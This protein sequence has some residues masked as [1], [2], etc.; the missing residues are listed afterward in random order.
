MQFTC[1]RA[2]LT[3][4]AT[5]AARATAARSPVPALEGLLIEAFESGIVRITGYDLKIGIVTEIEADVQ[6]HGVVVLTA[7]LL[8]EIVR[9]MPGEDV[10]FTAD[11][12]KCR[13]TSEQSS[14][15]LIG[16]PAKEYPELP[17]LDGQKA[18]GIEGKLLRAVIGET[19]FAV[20]ESEARPVFSGALFE[21][22]GNRL[23]V[24]AV[25]GARLAL[26][27]E[28]I[29]NTDGGDSSFIVP[30]SALAE[31]E[32][33]VSGED[34]DIEIIA[35]DK[36]VMFR[37]ERT[38]LVARRIVGEFLN[39]RTTVPQSGKYAI[40]VSRRDLTDAVERVSL[41]ISDKVRTPLRCT[42]GD[43]VVILSA[44]STIGNAKD[45]CGAVGDGEGMEIGFN[46]KYL[47]DSL[48]AAPAETLE[49]RMNSPSTA[50]V[51]LPKD[52]PD[53]ETA[54]FVYMVLPVRLAAMNN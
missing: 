23:T 24:V 4:A 52:D 7:R 3:N 1:D 32:R 20:A 25:D 30:G 11:D 19:I 42:F 15:D 43:G 39:Y 44:V 2:A 12:N 51:I 13:L 34:G 6:S 14:F 18:Y 47:L 17:T 41:I 10:T 27:R 5:T 26:R 31:V 33:I 21:V 22:E 29:A 49:L 28:E 37:F 35:G 45:E 46:N 16:T 36:H 40:S 50:C 53:V 54:A 8:C 48:R 9:R 38:T